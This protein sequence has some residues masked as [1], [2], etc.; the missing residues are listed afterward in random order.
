LTVT[1][2]NK[3][4]VVG[5]RRPVFTARYHGFVDVDN[6][7]ALGGTLTFHTT[8]LTPRTFAIVPSGLTSS[9]Y[10]I[11]F[12][13]GRLTLVSRS[14]TA[15]RTSETVANPPV[16]PTQAPVDDV[17]TVSLIRLSDSKSVQN[18]PSVLIAF[19]SPASSLSLLALAFPGIGTSNPGAHS[20]GGG[21][22]VAP[23]AVVNQQAPGPGSEP[24][25]VAPGALARSMM[26]AQDTGRRACSGAAI[27]G[28]SLEEEDQEEQDRLFVQLGAS[29]LHP[30][31]DPFEEL[32]GPL[33]QEEEFP[34]WTQPADEADD[35]TV[36]AATWLILTTVAAE[37]SVLASRSR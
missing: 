37:V 13:S 8:A 10:H 21:G 5:G 11:I 20:D 23:D 15:T 2:N 4:E 29:G 19:A 7:S 22:L 32:L 34:P 3:R 27:V 35:G 25:V 12:V 18:S 17:L 14:A 16:P 1:A 28:P 9:D 36:L 24:S 31:K 33:G 6:P 26:A 30:E